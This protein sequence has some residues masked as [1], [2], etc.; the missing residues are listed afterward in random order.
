MRTADDAKHDLLLVIKHVRYAVEEAKTKGQAMLGVLSV[1]P[2]GGGKIECRFDSAFLD[3][4]AL[5]IGAPELTDSDR[6]GCRAIKFT[7]ELGLR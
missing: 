6:A 2:N 1:Q 4:V 5:L 3:D 7:H